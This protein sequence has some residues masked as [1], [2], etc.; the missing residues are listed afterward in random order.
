MRKTS[1]HY[2]GEAVRTTLLVKGDYD[3]HFY[4]TGISLPKY[5][6]ESSS[7]NSFEKKINQL[8]EYYCH[9]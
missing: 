9:E 6:T 8:R 4:E 1:P 7:V 2:N 3:E 5:V